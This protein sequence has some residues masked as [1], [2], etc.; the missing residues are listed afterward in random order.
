MSRA[1][2]P[3]LL[4]VLAALAAPGCLQSTEDRCPLCGMPPDVYDGPRGRLVLQDGDTVTFCSTA[5]LFRVL[6]QPDFDHD[7]VAAVQVQDVARAGWKR[8]E[9]G[10]IDARDAHYVAGSDR[11]AAMG[12]TLV[13]FANEMAAETFAANH[14]GEVYTFQEL[15]GDTLKQHAILD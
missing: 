14:G 13:S 10:W 3:L 6:T 7:T 1:A 2:L 15:D 12:P 11:R 9:G 8:P 4:L 5:E